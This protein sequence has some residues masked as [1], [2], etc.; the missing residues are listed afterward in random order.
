MTT[1]HLFDPTTATEPA[2]EP[3]KKSPVRRRLLRV[4][5]WAAGLV[6]LAA[7]VFVATPSPIHPLAWSPQPA[8][9]LTGVL[10]PND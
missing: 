4:A 9:A 7:I 10:A 1:G 8:P 6:V 2:P 5:A 3:V